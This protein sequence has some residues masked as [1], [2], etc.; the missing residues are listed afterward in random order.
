MLSK[1][2]LRSSA[3]YCK[4]DPKI[5]NAEIVGAEPSGSSNSALPALDE[6]QLAFHT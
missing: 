3:I 6:F 4:I 5:R 2:D 1:R